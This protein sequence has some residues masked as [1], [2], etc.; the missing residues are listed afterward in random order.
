MIKKL[1]L[2]TAGAA[3]ILGA[4]AASAGT[5]KFTFGVTGGGAY[6]DGMTL[7]E[8]GG[9]A[10]GFHTGCQDDVAGGIEAGKLA[11]LGVEDSRWIITTTDTNSPDNQYV[12]V[13]DQKALTWQ[14]YTLSTTDSVTFELV[15]SGPLIRGVPKEV[16]AGGVALSARSATHPQ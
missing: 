9:L 2:S 15:N 14:V 1:M 4:T 8:S 3:L 16:A 5:V 10:T 11:S 7:S 6:C 12:F 13:L